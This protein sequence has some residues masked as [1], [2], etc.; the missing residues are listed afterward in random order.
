MIV[1]STGIVS[2]GRIR[3]ISPVRISSAA[4][5]SSLPSVILLPCAGARQISFFKPFLARFVVISSRIAPIAIIKA[6]SPAANR[7]PI[8]IAASIAIVISKAEEILLM[9]GL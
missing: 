5:S 2:P 1:P 7:S 4:I 9:P 8:T 3:R 6:T